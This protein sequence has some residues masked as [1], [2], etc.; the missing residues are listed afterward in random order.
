MHSKVG[1]DKRLNYYLESGDTVVAQLNSHREG[2]TNPEAA[3]RLDQNGYHSLAALPSTTPVTAF[4]HHALSWQSVSL[5]IATALVWHAYGGNAGIVVVL[6]WLAVITANTW[7]EQNHT[8]LAYHLDQLLPNKAVVMRSSVESVV[9]SQTLVVGDVISLQHGDVVPADVRL[10]SERHFTTDDHALTGSHHISHKYVHALDHE[11]P[12][13]QR[14]NL[15]LAGTTVTSGNARGIVIATGL[16]TEIG[17]IASLAYST[18]SHW[19]MAELALQRHSHRW[20]VGLIGLTA[21][22]YAMHWGGVLPGNVTETLL[23]VIAVAASLGGFSFASAWLLQRTRKQAARHGAQLSSASAASDL[24]AVDTLLL[25]EDGFVLDGEQSILEIHIGKQSYS[26]SGDSYEPHGTLMRSTGRS[27]GKKSLGDLKLFFEA[28]AFTSRASL[29]APDAEHSRW[30]VAGPHDDGLLLALA[31]KVGVDSTELHQRSP[32]HSHYK[33]DHS[34]RLTSAIHQYDHRTM[35]FVRG[36]ADTV[37][38]RSTR[39]W[40]GG[41]TR[42]LSKAERA[43]LTTYHETHAANG[44]HVVALAYRALTGKGASTLPMHDAEQDLTLLGL[45]V[46]NHSMHSEVTKQLAALTNAGMQV[47]LLSNRSAAQ[48][49]ACAAQ[50]GISVET[51]VTGEQLAHMA[52]SQLAELLDQGVALVHVS[53]EQR[54]HIV[55]VAQDSRQHVAISGSGLQSIPALRH[56]QVGIVDVRA[57]A[58]VREEAGLVLDD[59]DLG[60]ISNAID[61]SRSYVRALRTALMVSLT[62]SAALAWLTLTSAGLYILWHTPIAVM[63]LLS[64]ALLVLASSSLASLVSTRRRSRRPAGDAASFRG[65]SVALTSY[66]GKGLLAAF[67]AIL[68]FYG[69]FGQ[70]QLSPTYIP[71]IGS[72]GLSATTIAFVSLVGI[73]LINVWFDRN[74]VHRQGNRRLVPWL[75]V[76]VVLTL[77]VVYLPV[78]NDVFNSRP[79]NAVG[80]LLT[81]S[82]T[83]GYALMRWAIQHEH[84]HSRH[85][86]IELHH[87][88][89]G[90]GSSAKV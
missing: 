73:Q 45:V 30:H 76:C 14:H 38:E 81:L 67:F 85:A 56:A 11:V 8:S 25:D 2:L 72:F 21:A 33:Y 54:L 23:A 47:S 83:A 36:N 42:Q 12:L 39:L 49:R 55:D 10:I 19:S 3:R 52:D 40:D 87:E 4:V 5:L 80:W 22:G 69:Y 20:L 59:N 90:H 74:T 66:T 35:V 37:L 34:R 79:I 32:E 51:V 63:P 77:L 26:V 6:F 28:A 27:V 15:A 13:S 58:A 62:D 43:R 44:D 1:T 64:V 29:L 89:H 17:R 24:A 57:I 82:A 86:I 75:T 7:R 16:H 9:D 50:A 18:P 60:A 61:S 70:Q 84:R 78:A 68:A 65:I 46:I 71:T 48:V 88:V 41:H 31:H 53:P